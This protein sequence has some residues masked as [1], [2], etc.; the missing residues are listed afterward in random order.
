QHFS[1]RH[2]GIY[3]PPPQRGLTFCSDLGVSHRGF[4]VGAVQDLDDDGQAATSPEHGRRLWC[5]GDLG[6]S[7]ERSSCL[8]SR[9]NSL[10]TLTDTE[11]ENKSDSE[12]GRKPP[13]LLPFHSFR[14]CFLDFAGL[15]VSTLACLVF[16]LSKYYT[17][18]K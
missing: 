9:S 7:S 5:R 10:L 3:E 14:R 4:S 13:R 8:S 11:H 6:K 1:L 16:T 2:L 12:N 18:R 17:K 15:S